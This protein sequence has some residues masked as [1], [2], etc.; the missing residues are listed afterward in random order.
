VARDVESE[1]V[2]AAREGGMGIMPWSP[3][4]GGFLTGKYKRGSTASSG[5]LSG[6]NPFGDSK[7]TDRNWDILDVLEAVAKDVERPV[8]Q[9][10]L[11]WTLTRSGVASTLIGARKVSQ[12]ESNIAAT[13]LQLTSD[14]LV[15]LN[16]ASAPPPGFSSSL[17]TPLIRRMV[18]GGHNVVGWG[19]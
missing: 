2:P 19:E 11:A 10:A 16:E 18:F 17:T 8:A 4:A 7:F 5:R 1:H 3:L 13:E 15:R 6:A 9:V 14:Q 12:L